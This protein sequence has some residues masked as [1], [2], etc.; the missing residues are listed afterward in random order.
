[1]SPVA[2]IL[3]TAVF[4]GVWVDFYRT[5]HDLSITPDDSFW[6]GAWWLG[7]LITVLLYVLPGITLF[8]FPRDLGAASRKKNDGNFE[9]VNGHEEETGVL[10]LLKK[11]GLKGIQNYLKTLGIH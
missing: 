1:M 3:M 4:L 11:D 7:Y 8:G 2:G 10:T 5:D 9:L 6:V